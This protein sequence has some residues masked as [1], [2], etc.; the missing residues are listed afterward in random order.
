MDL[1][2]YR[3]NKLVTFVIGCFFCFKISVSFAE[4]E[5]STIGKFSIIKKGDI[6]P[7]DGILYDPT[8]NAIIL[9][10]PELINEKSKIDLEHKEQ[11][12]NAKYKFELDS[13]RIELNSNKEVSKKLLENKEKEIESLRKIAI[14][15]N[16]YTLLYVAGGFVGGVLLAGISVWLA[17][18][19]ND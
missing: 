6:A 10:E 11:T 4:T 7:L 3:P 2:M 12:L 8:A 1:F 16:D 17:G 13:L 19:L 15:A 9:S 14:N 18:K 5:T